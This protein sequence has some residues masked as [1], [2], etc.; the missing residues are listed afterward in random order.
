MID[1]K[2]CCTWGWPRIYDVTV[3][4][5]QL[6]E[7]PARSRAARAHASRT[8]TELGTSSTSADVSCFDVVSHRFAT[9]SVGPNEESYH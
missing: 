5:G 9:R 1:K 2:E 3:T 6:S 4:T 8:L 7:L